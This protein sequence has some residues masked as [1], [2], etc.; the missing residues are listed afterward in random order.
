[1]TLEQDVQWLLESNAELRDRVLGLE[2]RLGD[3]QERVDGL[4]VMLQATTKEGT[5]PQ[6]ITQLE[7]DYHGIIT[8]FFADASPRSSRNV[9]ERL[10]KM[11]DAI[12]ALGPWIRGLYDEAMR[13]NDGQ[14]V[15]G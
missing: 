7:Q 1:M 4:Y 9:P 14:E 10:Q 12:E 2:G 3:L 8:Y 15:L 13:N 5:L 6:R 11:E